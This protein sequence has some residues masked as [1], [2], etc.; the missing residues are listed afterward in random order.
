MNNVFVGC[1][2]AQHSAMISSYH[3]VIRNKDEDRNLSFY[4]GR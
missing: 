4:L 2:F 1:T 3:I